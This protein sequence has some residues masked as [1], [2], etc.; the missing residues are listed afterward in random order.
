MEKQPGMPLLRLAYSTLFLIALRRALPTLRSGRYATWPAPPDVWAGRRA[1]MAFAL[2]GALGAP[3]EALFAL[4][5]SLVLVLAYLIYAHA[6]AWS[7]YYLEAHATLAYLTAL[8]L[9]RVLSG[10]AARISR[11]VTSSA[12]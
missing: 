9:W 5:S 4:A 12:R 6:A 8:G 3:P 11:W 10:L 2:L 7:V 1:L